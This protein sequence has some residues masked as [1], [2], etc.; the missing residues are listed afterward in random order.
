M[1]KKKPLGIM[2]LMS[3]GKLTAPTKEELEREFG[4]PWRKPN[5]DT[6]YC[7]IELAEKLKKELPEIFK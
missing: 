6:I 4:S 7:G 1:K 2:A 3:V 5:T